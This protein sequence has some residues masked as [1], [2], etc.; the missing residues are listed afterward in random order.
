MRKVVGNSF[1]GDAGDVVIVAA[2]VGVIY[3]KTS[4]PRPDIK[5]RY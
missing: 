5:R 4:G 1:D 2:C 3:R